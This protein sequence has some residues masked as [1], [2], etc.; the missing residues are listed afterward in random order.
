MMQNVG[1]G[2]M[3]QN[4]AL[5]TW[6]AR[7]VGSPHLVVSGFSLL[8]LVHAVAPPASRIAGSATLMESLESVVSSAADDAVRGLAART[9]V[10]AYRL[11]LESVQRFCGPRSCDP[12]SVPGVATQWS[13]CVS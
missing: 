6:L 1:L 13:C 2:P 3:F 4:D 9:L 10:D 7:L 5:W 11:R 8:V 12:I